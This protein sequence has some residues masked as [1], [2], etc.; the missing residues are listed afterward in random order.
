MTARHG[1]FPRTIYCLAVYRWLMGE[2]QEVIEALWKHWKTQHPD[3]FPVDNTPLQQPVL[4][5]ETTG[6]LP[7]KSVQITD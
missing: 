4:L 3:Q 6:I 7:D 1:S 2:Q 5:T